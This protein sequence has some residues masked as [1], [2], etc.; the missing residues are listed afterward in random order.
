MAA[1]CS[2]EIAVVPAIKVAEHVE[3]ADHLEARTTQHIANRVTQ[4]ALRGFV[5]EYDEPF[6]VAGKG[7]IA[8]T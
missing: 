3:S 1:H 2:L 6:L 8:G 5:P 4:Q 7:C